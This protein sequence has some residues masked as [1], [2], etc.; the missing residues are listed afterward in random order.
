MNRQLKKAVMC[1]G[2]LL[3]LVLGYGG[4]AGAGAGGDVQVTAGGPDSAPLLRN[5]IGWP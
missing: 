2:I 5:E 4:Y 1:V 3:T